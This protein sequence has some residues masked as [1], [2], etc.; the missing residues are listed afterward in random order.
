LAIGDGLDRLMMCGGVR[1]KSMSNAQ[2][3]AIYSGLSADSSQRSACDETGRPVQ[4]VESDSTMKSKTQR[5]NGITPYLMTVRETAEYIRRSEKAVRHLYERGKLTPLRG[6]D[7][8]VH[9]DRREIDAKYN[10]EWEQLNDWKAL[11]RI[12]C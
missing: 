7:G 5:Y 1:T 8:R 3:V 9:I 11:M 4:T 12:R 6:L 10:K 2:G